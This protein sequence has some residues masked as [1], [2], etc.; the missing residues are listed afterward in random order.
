MGFY[1]THMYPIP[2]TVRLIDLEI[3]SIHIVELKAKNM[4]LSTKTTNHWFTVGLSSLHF[5]N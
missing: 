3:L 5:S 1:M 2:F 4:Q